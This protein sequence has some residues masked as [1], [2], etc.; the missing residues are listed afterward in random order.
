MPNL[1]RKINQNKWKTNI[2][3]TRQT[4][5]ADSITG[6]IRTSQ[7]TLS[8]WKSTTTDFNDS[9]VEELVIAL[10]TTTDRPDP[11]DVIWFNRNELE[12]KGFKLEDSEGKTPYEAINNRHCDIINMNYEKL[13]DLAE[14]IIQKFTS[15]DNNF[16]R[17]P[18]ST[19]LNLVKKKVQNGDIDIRK[20]KDKWKTAIDPTTYPAPNKHKI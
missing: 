14:Y 12:E 17:F 8:L 9:D 2:P 20:L 7:N 1:L 11:I 5:T 10:A 3:L 18:K 4:Y 15:D 16:K 13:G 6:C 19:V